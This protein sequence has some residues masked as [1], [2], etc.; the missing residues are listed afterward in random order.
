[1]H[2]HC[3]EYP[4]S[5]TGSDPWLVLR[6][7]SRHEKVVESS[8]EQKQ[9]TAYLPKTRVINV[10]DGRKRVSEMPLFPG[11]VFVR[12]RADQYEGIRFIRGSCGLVFADAKPATLPDKDLEAVKLLVD[13]GAT[14]TVDSDLVVGKRV[15]ITGGP[16]AG[17]EGELVSMKNQDLLSIN[18]EMVG[19]CVRVEVDHEMVAAL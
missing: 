6:T 18:V 19:S 2:E 5:G 13:S 12:P 11:Y 8:L 7:R 9:I 3:S 10:K 16:F 17:V 14:L 4:Y 15:R 1:M